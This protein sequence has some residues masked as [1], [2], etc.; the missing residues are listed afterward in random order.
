MKFNP[1][2]VFAV[3]AVCVGIGVGIHAQSAMGISPGGALSTCPAPAAKA[4]IFCNVAGDTANPDGAYV[5][6]NGATYMGPLAPATAS[7]VTSFNK[8]TGAVLPAA[9]DYT[10]SQL[11][12][13]PTTITCTTFTQSNTGA[14][15]SGCTIK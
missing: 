3:V 9:N 6:A 15:G 7:G 8:R 2:I 1:W 13:P 14:V 10:Y 11:S 5:S 12:A 4:L